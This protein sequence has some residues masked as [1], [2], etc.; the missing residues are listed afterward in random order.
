MITEDFVVTAPKL[1]PYVPLDLLACNLCGVRPPNLISKLWMGLLGRQCC[2]YS[3]SFCP[4]G[5]APVEDIANPIEAMMRGNSESRPRCGGIA[6]P[7][8]H[9][10]C[11]CCDHIRL[12]H[13]K[14]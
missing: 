2:I 9:M 11:N 3:I 6:E 1:E 14:S 5:R 4:G 8:L 12:M 10:K 13:T 7:H